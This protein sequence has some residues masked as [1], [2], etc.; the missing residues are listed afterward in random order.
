[1][2]Q[3]GRVNNFLFRILGSVLANF[4]LTLIGDQNLFIE[5]T[6]HEIIWGYPDPLQQVLVMLGLSDDPLVHIQVSVIV[7]SNAYL[8]CSY[9][10]IQVILKYFIVLILVRNQW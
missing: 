7:L 10:L 3:Q 4:Y 9:R 1:M 5:K 6:A 8:N 2:N